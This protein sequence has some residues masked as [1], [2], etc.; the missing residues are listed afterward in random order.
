MFANVPDPY[1]ANW[2]CSRDM[3]GEGIMG[4]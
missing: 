2:P 3:L 4:M 1:V